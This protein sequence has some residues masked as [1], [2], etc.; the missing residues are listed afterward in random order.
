MGRNRIWGPAYPRAYTRLERG[1][2]EPWE[3]EEHRYEWAAPGTALSDTYE[4][5]AGSFEHHASPGQRGI[6]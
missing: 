3:V 6:G 5:V 1:E 2:P 4:P